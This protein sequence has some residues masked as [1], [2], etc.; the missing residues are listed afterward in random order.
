MTHSPQTFP[1]KVVA[2]T[3]MDPSIPNALRLLQGCIKGAA[4]S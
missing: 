4:Q 1:L 3:K 2:V